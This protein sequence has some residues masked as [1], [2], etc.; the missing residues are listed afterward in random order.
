MKLLY[1]YRTK[2]ET[3]IKLSNSF[4]IKKE[5]ATEVAA[6]SSKEMSALCAEQEI[7]KYTEQYPDAVIE[8]EVIDF[9]IIE[10]KKLKDEDDNSGK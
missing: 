1:T 5:F 9:E 8:I 6:S 10:I 3:I 7:A 2:G 4:S